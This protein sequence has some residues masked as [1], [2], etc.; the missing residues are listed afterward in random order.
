MSLKILSSKTFKRFITSISRLRLV[1]RSRTLSKSV[2][3]VSAFAYRGDRYECPLCKGRFSEFLNYGDPQNKSLGHDIVPA[4]YRENVLCPS[5]GSVERERLLRLYIELRTDALKRSMRLLHVAPERNLERFLSSHPQL[6]YITMDISDRAMLRADLCRLGIRDS[7]F[8][9]IICSHVLEHV[10]D[11]MR[12]M[13]EMHRV[14]NK[15]GW[16]IIQ[17]PLSPS[18]EKTIEGDDDDTPEK[19]EELFGQSNHVRLYGKDYVKRL[20]A[21]GFKV[22]GVPPDVVVGADSVERYALNP[23][24]LLFVCS[25]N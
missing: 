4:S 21:A 11:D 9:A 1:N 12:A 5:C 20:E 24:E 8:D 19:R 13:S 18:L 23:K 16:A 22:D 7:A 3:R 15:G 6:E 14:L 25:K 2:R 17:V 10:K